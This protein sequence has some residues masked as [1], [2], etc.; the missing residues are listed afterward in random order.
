MKGDPVAEIIRQPLFVPTCYHPRCCIVYRLAS[1][2]LRCTRRP[3]WQ[4]RR[5]GPRGQDFNPTQRRKERTMRRLGVTV[6]WN[7]LDEDEF[8]TWR[9]PRR[10]KDW[11]LGETVLVVFQPR[12][13]NQMLGIATILKKE[14]RALSRV[15]VTTDIPLPTEEEATWDGFQSLGS[16][17]AWFWKVYRYRV[18]EET[19][20]KLTLRWEYPGLTRIRLTV[21]RRSLQKAK[22]LLISVVGKS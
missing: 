1:G 21:L 16:M 7:K 2:R 4:C 8:T 5:D 20:N 9:F 11:I 18:F 3:W 10:D 22:E 15:M 17:L 14:P 19:A 12:H 6:C 13:D